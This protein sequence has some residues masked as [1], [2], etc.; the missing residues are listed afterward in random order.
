MKYGSGAISSVELNQN[1]YCFMHGRH[2]YNSSNIQTVIPKLMTDI[3]AQTSEYFNRN[4][5]VNASECKPVS[6]SKVFF[7]H[8]ITVPRSQQCSLADKADKNGYVA[9]GTKVICLCMN[10]NIKDLRIIDVL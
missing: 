3:P 8:Y 5:F 1:E 4:I 2:Y 9:D 6:D 10:N 7:Q